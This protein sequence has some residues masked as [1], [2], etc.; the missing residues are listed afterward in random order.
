M[1]VRTINEK[2]A[3]IGADLIKTE[4]SLRDLAIS[5][6]EVVF[7]SS[8]Y[9]KKNGAKITH[10]ECEKIADR[11]KWGIP[12]DFTITVFEPNIEG[13]SDEQI[14][15]LLFHELLHIRIDT[16]G[17]GNESYGIYPHDLEDFKEIVDRFGTDWS[18]VD[19]ITD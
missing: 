7:L 5:N 18:R 6:A 15:I 13:F 19:G 17:N 1:D 16:D 11:Y 3:E 4:S 9:K 8:E 12:A 10:A 2:Y 14:R